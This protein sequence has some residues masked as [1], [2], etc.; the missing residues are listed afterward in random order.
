LLIGT[1]TESTY[2][3][4]VAGDGRFQG[5][6]YTRSGTNVGIQLVSTSAIRNDG[7]Q[8]FDYGTSGSGDFFFRGGSGFATVLVLTNTTNVGIG[9]TTFGTSATKTLAIGSGVAPTT[10]P[11]DAFQL[12][13]AD[14]TAGNAAPHFRTEGGAVITV[15]EKL[16]TKTNTNL[17]LSTNDIGRVTIDTS[18]NVGIGTTNP[19]D[20]LQVGS[21]TSASSTITIGSGTASSGSL[22]F[23]DGSGADRYRGIVNYYHATDYMAIGA[24]GVEYM[25]LRSDGKLG[26]G[27]ASPSAILHVSNDT[28]NIRKSNAAG[29]VYVEVANDGIFAT[30]TSLTLFAPTSQPL[31]FSSGNGEAGRFVANKNLLLGQTSDTGERLQI[32]GAL[33]TSAPTGGTAAAWKFGAVA[34]VTPTS[35]NR[36]IEVE[37]GGT[38]YYLTA[39]T[40]ND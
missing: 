24:G 15:S 4:D 8:Y 5:T 40:T 39:K 36:T 20:L 3:L 32:N 16:G 26:L 27:V 34:T 17:T 1:T 2:L 37:I 13:S 23:G 19:L 6:L 30:G 25:F 9:Q 31:I 18:G 29:T 21:F 10:S 11:A 35:Q 22:Y 14:I 38:T 12:Y 7:T 33:R 28:L